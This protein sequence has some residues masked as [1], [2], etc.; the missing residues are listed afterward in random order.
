MYI[1]YMGTALAE[2][3]F[4]N[5]EV[6]PLFDIRFEVALKNKYTKFFRKNIFDHS[7]FE[8]TSKKADLKFFNSI[9]AEAKK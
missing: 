7:F 6:V 5:S 3:Y 9:L 1:G 8:K 2:S 4:L